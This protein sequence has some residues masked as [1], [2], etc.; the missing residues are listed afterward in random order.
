MKNVTGRRADDAKTRE[1]LETIEALSGELRGVCQG[2]PYGA[3]VIASLM[4]SLTV[5]EQ[6]LDDPD[7]KPATRELLRRVQLANTRF[8]QAHLQPYGASIQLE[9]VN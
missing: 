9:R 3:V 8:L 5:V 1:W 7:L 4:L 2:K 6:E